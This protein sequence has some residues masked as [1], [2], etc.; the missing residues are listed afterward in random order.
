MMPDGI[1][2][3]DFQA[4]RQHIFLVFPHRLPIAIFILLAAAPW[5]HWRFSLRTML[6]AVAVVAL[7]FGLAIPFDGNVCAQRERL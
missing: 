5:I 1:G 3:W 2:P 6:I 7:V 4:G